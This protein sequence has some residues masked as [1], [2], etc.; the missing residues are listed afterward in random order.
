MTHFK[1][2][3]DFTSN[4]KLFKPNF[5]DFWLDFTDYS[6]LGIAG[7]LKFQDEFQEF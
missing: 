7:I 1:N 5:R 4:F 6:I 2:L 3:R